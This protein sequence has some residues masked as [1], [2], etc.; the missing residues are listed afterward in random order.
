[1]DLADKAAENSTYFEDI[2]TSCKVKYA[3]SSVLCNRASLQT[4]EIAL[5]CMWKQV[6]CCYFITF[7]LCGNLL[8]IFQ[9]MR[10]G[11]QVSPT[12]NIDQQPTLFIHLLLLLTSS[13]DKSHLWLGYNPWITEVQIGDIQ[14]KQVK[15]LGRRMEH[16]SNGN[17]KPVETRTFTLIHPIFMSYGLKGRGTCI[18]LV[19]DALNG[20]YILKDCWLPTMW[21][22]DIT[23]HQLLQDKSR[24]DPRFSV[25]V[26]GKGY[27]VIFGDENQYHIFDNPLFKETSRYPGSLRGIP[28][29]VCWDEVQRRDKVGALVLETMAMLLGYP[30]D[31]SDSEHHE[32]RLHL[33]AAFSKCG[34]G[35]TWFLCAREFFNAMMG[36]LVG[37]LLCIGW[38][39]KKY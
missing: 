2:T 28:M 14:C 17:I 27:E 32:D 22:N 7:S 8:T 38:M 23:I 34:I 11:P 26:R 5:F 10:G 33:R 3:D 15:L 20:Y 29:L 1:M 4:S 6:D 25:E 37:T 31:L 36:V 24:E 35:I 39:V 30:F 18:W 19:Q 13:L 21:A 12:I 9:Y 16:P